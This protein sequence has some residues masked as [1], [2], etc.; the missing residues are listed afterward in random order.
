MPGEPLVHLAC[1]SL[2]LRVKPQIVRDTVLP[3]QVTGCTANLSA[4]PPYS[5]RYKACEQHRST[6][7]VVFDGKEQ[8]FCQQVSK[9]LLL[10]CA[11]PAF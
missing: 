5:W 10:C 1:S 8:R 4:E 11:A 7:C 3:M 9:W 2:Q 6:L